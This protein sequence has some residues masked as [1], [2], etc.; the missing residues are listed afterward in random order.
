M[1]LIA[2]STLNVQTGQ[3]IL[4][5]G[6]G[7][8][9]LIDRLLK[10]RKPLKITA[11]DMSHTAVAMALNRFRTAIAADR[12][13]VHQAT[14]EAMPFADNTFD[15]IVTV[16]TVYFWADILAAFNECKRCLKP[17]GTLV[18]TYNSKAFLEAQQVTQLGFKAYD[19]SETEALLKRVGFDAV[20]TTSDESRSNGTFFCTS[21]IATKA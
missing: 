11:I 9:D 4:E 3:H 12:L 16:N 1:N 8:G 5:I 6:F 17:G 18:A 2:L 7:G 20:E 21:G 19:A 13:V 14:A 10:T 15:A